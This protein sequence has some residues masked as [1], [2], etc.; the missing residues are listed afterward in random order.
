MFLSVG[1]MGFSYPHVTL[2]ERGHV[3][4]FSASLFFLCG[5]WQRRYGGTCC[6]SRTM[7]LCCSWRLGIE[8]GFCFWIVLLK[9]YLKVAFQPIFNVMCMNNI[10]GLY[11]HLHPSVMWKWLRP[12]RCRSE[13]STNGFFIC[14]IILLRLDDC[15][16]LRNIWLFVVHDMN[17]LWHQ[18][19]NKPIY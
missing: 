17:W 15:S 6:H 9:C 16:R 12:T 14:E 8:F 10:C 3:S 18:S 13:G 1:F 19:Q 7:C 11:N 5:H 4:G 2:F